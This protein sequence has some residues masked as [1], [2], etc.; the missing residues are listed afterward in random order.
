M[1]AVSAVA[2]KTQLVEE[3][4]EDFG[5]QLIHKLEVSVFISYKA[6]LGITN[7]SNIRN[8]SFESF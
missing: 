4:A 5:P 3:E 8:L 1:A 6:Q 7:L 2:A